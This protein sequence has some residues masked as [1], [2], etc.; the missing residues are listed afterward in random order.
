VSEQGIRENQEKYVDL[1][2]EGGGV[3]DIALVGAFY[4]LEKRRYEPQDMAGA[5]G[6]TIVAALVAAS[7]TAA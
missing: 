5:S 6:G 3:K 4:V 7:Y 2:F 1:V